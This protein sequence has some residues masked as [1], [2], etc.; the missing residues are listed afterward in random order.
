ML[1]NNFKVDPR[2]LT[3]KQLDIDYKPLLSLIFRNAFPESVSSLVDAL[4]TQFISASQAV[5]NYIDTYYLNRVD[6]QSL[7][8]KLKECKPKGPLCCNVLKQYYNEKEG[9]F[10]CL[11][12]IISGTI[13]EG[14]RI[15]ILGEGFTTLEQE[16][17]SKTTVKGLYL[18]MEGGRYKISVD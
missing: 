15:K 18:V 9:S 2:K 12:R 7:I 5:P 17:I 3:T 16:D 10:E 8:K 14:Q 4:V 13:S 11:A 6:D 1:S